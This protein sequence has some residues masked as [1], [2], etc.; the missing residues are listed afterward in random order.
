M[1][2]AKITYAG[3]MMGDDSAMVTATKGENESVGV[4]VAEDNGETTVTLSVGQ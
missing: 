2:D 4:S 1:D 3:S